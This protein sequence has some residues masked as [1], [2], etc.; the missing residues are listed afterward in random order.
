MYLAQHTVKVADLVDS[1]RAD[2]IEWLPFGGI[3]Q[4]IDDWLTAAGVAAAG[5]LQLL[6]CH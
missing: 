4:M 3:Q 6:A 1:H 2:R 5:F